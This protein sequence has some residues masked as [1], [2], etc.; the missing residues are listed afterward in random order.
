MGKTSSPTDSVATE[1]ATAEQP[2]AESGEVAAESAP[3]TTSADE[4]EVLEIAEKVEADSV[5]SSTSE[6]VPEPQKDFSFADLLK[7]PT[8]SRELKKH[9]DKQIKTAVQRKEEEIRIA[10]EREEMSEVERLRA[11]LQ[12]FQAKAQTA[13]QEAERARLNSAFSD[14]LVDSGITPASAKAREYL[15]Q[16]AFRIM[17]EDGLDMDVCLAEAAKESPFLLAKTAE[18][19]E[20][21]RAASPKVVAQTAPKPAEKSTEKPAA[22][23]KDPGVDVFSMSPQEFR[24]YRRQKYGIH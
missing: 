16:E 14:A 3:A 4:A 23:E 9:V 19:P 10:K 12:D 5:E 11:E 22:P 21:K 2:V 18:S 7:D 17:E 15:R 24:E 20:T 8:I 13:A 6:H 1:A